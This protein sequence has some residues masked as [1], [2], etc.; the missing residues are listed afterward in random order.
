MKETPRMLEMLIT[1]HGDG[2]QAGEAGNRE[3]A[4]T[5]EAMHTSN[6]TT[7]SSLLP[8]GNSVQVRSLKHYF[9]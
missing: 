8:P 2:G 5:M 3:S 1:R 6:D 9:S 7:C 4:L